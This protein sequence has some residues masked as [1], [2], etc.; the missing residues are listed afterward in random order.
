MTTTA[1]ECDRLLEELGRKPDDLALREQ[2]TRALQR[3]GREAEA[4]SLLTGHLRNLTGHEPPPL[5]CLCRKCIDP[6]RTTTEA[7]GFTFDREFSVA[8]GRVLFYWVPRE[9]RGR[10]AAVRRSV[11]S[12]LADKLRAKKK[13]R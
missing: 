10:R 5:P 8:E 11:E 4:I 1:S 12:A 3:A 6:E 2:A 13:R 7:L 9:V